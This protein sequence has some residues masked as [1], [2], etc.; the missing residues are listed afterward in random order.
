MRTIYRRRLFLIT[1]LLAAAAA[2]AFRIA[3]YAFG[4]RHVP[5]S[6]VEAWPALM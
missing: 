6:T 4:L 3:F 1:L 5:F 2:L